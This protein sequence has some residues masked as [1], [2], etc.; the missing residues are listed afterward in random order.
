MTWFSVVGLISA[1]ALFAPIIIILI[2]RLTWYKSFPALW[3]YFFTVSL[4]VFFSLGLVDVNKTFMQYW[5]VSNNFLDAPLMLTFMTYFSRTPNVKRKMAL[6]IAAFLVF[7]LAVIVT[8][9]YT[10]DASVIVLAPGLLLVLLFSTLFFVHQTKITVVYQ[11][12][13]GKAFI[14]AALLFAYGGYS[15]IYTVYYLMKTPYKNDTHVIYFLI[16]IVSSLIIATG[17]L[18]ERKR[19]RQLNELKVARQELRVI[20]GQS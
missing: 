6:T 10:V 2:L 13:A 11:K 7:E 9:G 15:Y 8:K 18:L 4:Y 5:G 3:F 20:Y 14:T 19:V 1:I 17:I 12:A 16:T